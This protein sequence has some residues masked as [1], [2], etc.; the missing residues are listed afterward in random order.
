MFWETLA[1]IILI[2]ATLP[3]WIF[4][5]IFWGMV[6][7]GFTLIAGVIGQFTKADATSEDLLLLPILAVFQGFASAWSVPVEIWNW[8]KFG[9]PWWAAVVG[10]IILGINSTLD[11]RR[12]G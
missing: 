1:A 4:L 7:A 12:R 6:R 10:L 8:G 2:I 9:N 3:Y 5:A 11:R